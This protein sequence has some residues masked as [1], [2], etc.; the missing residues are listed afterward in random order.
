MLAIFLA[1]DHTTIQEDAQNFAS[2]KA[3]TMVI[4]D[5][6]WKGERVDA[7]INPH[8]LPK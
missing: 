7:P 3:T 4:V 6:I 2:N 8:T 5:R 1:V